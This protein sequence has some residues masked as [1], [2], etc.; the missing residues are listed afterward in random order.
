MLGNVTLMA[1][2]EFDANPF[3]V[4]KF[5][6]DPRSN[7]ITSGGRFK[8]SEDRYRLNITNVQESDLGTYMVIFANLVHDHVTRYLSLVQP[9]NDSNYMN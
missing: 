6:T 9:G 2:L 5:W 7:S 8:I 1:F 4:G 3:P